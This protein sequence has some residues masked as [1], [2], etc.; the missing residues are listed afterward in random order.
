M[1]GEH[2]L[3]ARD[4]LDALNGGERSP[5]QLRHYGP[6]RSPLEEAAGQARLY[7]RVHRAQIQREIARV[8]RTLG[9]AGIPRVRACVHEAWRND[10]RIAPT[11]AVGLYED[12]DGT[13][14]PQAGLGIV[15]AANAPPV[16]F[17]A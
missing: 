7:L 6:A 3:A 17:S 9:R 1:C 15:I 2:D 8:D 13:P 5:S 14:R 10:G 12:P 4:L 16:A 11:A